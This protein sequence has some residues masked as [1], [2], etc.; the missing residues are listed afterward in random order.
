M[1]L[2]QG[3]R[4]IFWPLQ[5][6]RHQISGLETHPKR[7]DSNRDRTKTDTGTESWCQDRSGVCY[8]LYRDDCSPEQRVGGGGGE[9]RHGQGAVRSLV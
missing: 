4:P 2:S 6:S 7:F 9:G 3:P 8:T 1:R 5:R